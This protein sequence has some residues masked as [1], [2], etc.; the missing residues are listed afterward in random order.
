[1][2]GKRAGIVVVAGLVAACSAGPVEVTATSPSGAAA[3]ECAALVAALPDVVAD[4]ER[5]DVSPEDAPAA[6]WGEPPIVL[7][8]G[9]PKPAGLRPES[10]CFVVNDVGWFADEEPDRV[11]FTTIGRSTYV[12]MVVPNEYSPQA[13]ALPPVAAAI[14]AATSELRPCV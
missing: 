2:A 13:N 9:V 11:V 7:R 12:E 5:R 6:A 1:M 3:R 10:P 8:C 14:Q 4:Q